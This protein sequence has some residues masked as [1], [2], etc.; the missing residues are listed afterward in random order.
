MRFNFP[1]LKTG[2]NPAPFIIPSIRR[3]IG[4]R[5]EMVA[6]AGFGAVSLI[7]LAILKLASEIMEG[8][9]A[10]FDIALLRVM[11]AASQ[12]GTPLTSIMLGITHMGDGVTLTMLVLL[13]VGF[14]FAARKHGM[15]A[16]LIVAATVGTLLVQCLKQWV[17]RPRPEVVAHWTTFSSASFP[18]GHAA[19]SAIIYL[20]LA[21]LIA[22]SV[23]SNGVR[24][25]VVVSAMLLTF[26]IGLSR[27]YLGV[28]WPTDVL[29]GWILG[30]GWALF[31]WSVAWWL[32]SR[33]TL[34]RPSE[35]RQA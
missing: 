16:F 4:R 25:Y 8:E 3:A 30:T 28:H 33:R 19:N 14:L 21:V 18:S 24:I 23:A 11:R 10:A 31:C 9:T 22:R 1:A 6:L 15:A 29:S 5:P 26:L 2:R 7:L 20:T 32:Q 17:D 12:E 34:E 27:L 35:M 13:V